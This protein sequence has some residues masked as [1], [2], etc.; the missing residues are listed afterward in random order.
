MHINFKRQKVHV[1]EFCGLPAYCKFLITRYNDQLKEKIPP[2]EEFLPVELCNLEYESDRG[3]CIVP[4]FDDSWLWGERLVTVNLCGSTCLTFTLP[5]ND[6][7]N[8]INDELQRIQS[9]LSKE[10]LTDDT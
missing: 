7:V 10:I 2:D 4:H 5:S 6:A 1:G 3:A 9:C 8:G